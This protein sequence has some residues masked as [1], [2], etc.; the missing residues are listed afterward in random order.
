MVPRELIQEGVAPPHKGI[1]Q[2]KARARGLNVI[3]KC[4]CYDETSVERCY[5]NKK[6]FLTFMCEQSSKKLCTVRLFHTCNGNVKANAT[7]LD[8]HCSVTA[9]CI[10]SFVMMSSDLSHTR[11]FLVTL[12]PRQKFVDTVVMT[13]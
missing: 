8:E 13:S 9:V 4:L 6:L 12:N 2:S 10:D 5:I 1:T 3:V 7:S 11:S